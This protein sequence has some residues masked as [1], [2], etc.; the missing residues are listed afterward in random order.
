MVKCSFCQITKILYYY[1]ALTVFFSPII[2][3]VKVNNRCVFCDDFAQ[4]GKKKLYLFNHAV[5]ILQYSASI[6][7]GFWQNLWQSV[8]DHFL[9]KNSIVKILIEIEL[10]RVVIDH[11]SSL[12]ACI[13]HCS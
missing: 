11:K 7:L 9:H 5:S 12:N 2:Q 1:V 8:P 13:I 3:L 10:E 6:I 4:G